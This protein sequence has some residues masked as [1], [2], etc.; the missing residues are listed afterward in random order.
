MKEMN[1]AGNKRIRLLLSDG[2]STFGSAMLATQLNDRVDSGE[3]SSN[4]IIC[5]QKYSATVSCLIGSSA[6][7]DVYVLV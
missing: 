3:I 2:I 1:S 6:S 4:C 5:I 7:L